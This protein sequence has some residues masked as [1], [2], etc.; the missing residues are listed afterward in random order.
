MS[1]ASRK[2]KEIAERHNLLLDIA[3][4]L[5]NKEGYQQLN[6]NRI[7]ELAE[8]SKGTVYQH[9]HCKEEVLVQLCNRSL[10]K[11]LSLFTRAAQT[12]GNHRERMVAIFVAHAA[13]AEHE[14]K[15]QDMIQT[16]CADG[17]KEKVS[18][19]SLSEHSA[20]E[21]SLL[22]Q[23]VSITED[24]IQCGDLPPLQ[25]LTQQELVFGLWSLSHGGRLL[26]SAGLPLHELGIEKPQQAL[27][28]TIS[29][30]LDG[31]QWRPLSTEFDYQ[32][33]LERI[34]TTVFNEEL[35]N[36]D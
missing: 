5:L 20:L 15:N 26:I 13:W 18:P 34:Q 14:P 1:V 22:A 35:T 29:I 21:A 27:L 6:M 3:H 32:K 24:A 16:L 28:T 33:S 17:V 31:L 36:P 7:A 4:T 19:D 2:Q 23:V 11:L 12:E 25:Q 9:F 8:Y 30:T 10:K